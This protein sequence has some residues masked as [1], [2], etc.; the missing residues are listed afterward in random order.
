MARRVVCTPDVC[1][2]APR[3]D[4]TRLTCSN[5]VLALTNDALSI[6][7]FLEAHPYLEVSDIENALSYCAGMKCL[8]DRPESYCQG[9]LLDHR[10]EE[11]PSFFIEN[12]DD[13]RAY[14]KSGKD[15]GQAYLGSNQDYAEDAPKKVW[16]LAERILGER[17][18]DQAAKP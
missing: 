4:G 12:T 15:V 7:E 14:L 8:D 6:E 16:E 9:C 3:I 17:K 13:L 5:V 18:D 10:K 1:S 11:T 2:G